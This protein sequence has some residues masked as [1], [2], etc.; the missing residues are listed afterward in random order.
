MSLSVNPL[1]VC[2]AAPPHVDPV[3]GA[4]IVPV[5]VAPAV[6]APHVVILLD[7]PVSVC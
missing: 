2:P 7:V 5:P 6:A 1:P 4:P 3:F